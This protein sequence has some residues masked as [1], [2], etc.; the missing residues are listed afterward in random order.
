[1]QLVSVITPHFNNL[2]CLKETLESVARQTYTCYEHIVIDDCS[3]KLNDRELQSLVGSFP[4]TILIR[5]SV[6]S[7]A[8]TARNAGIKQAKGRFIAFVD[9]DDLWDPLKLEK[10]LEVMNSDNLDLCYSSYHVVSSKGKTLRLRQAPN[11][12]SYH[13]LL[14]CNEIGCLTAIYDTQRLGKVFMPEIRKR[15]DLALWLKLVRLGAK[16][17]GVSEPLAY[18]RIGDS[19][20]SS[21]KCKVLPYQWAVYRKCER[22][23]VIRSVYYFI[24]YAWNGL[25]HHY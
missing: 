10:Q 7:G 11:Q 15:Q 8:A 23:N 19:S 17:G 2:N 24:F 9:A 13:S 20:L 22:L 18:Y 25:I 5:L 4:N 16:S 12:V 6:N 21:N 3:S 1:M 14:K